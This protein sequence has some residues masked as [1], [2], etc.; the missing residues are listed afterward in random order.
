M[1]VDSGGQQ[2]GCVLVLMVL[3]APQ[4][5]VRGRAAPA[6]GSKAIRNGRYTAEF[7]KFPVPL[8]FGAAR[9]AFQHAHTLHLTGFGHR[10]FHRC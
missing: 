8:F 10:L 3:P 4:A 6:M 9:I 2:E 5:A 1:K 7:H